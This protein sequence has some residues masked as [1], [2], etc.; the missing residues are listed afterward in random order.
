MEFAG[1]QKNCK[2][3]L[4]QVTKDIKAN[5]DDIDEFETI[6][7]YMQPETNKIFYSINGMSNSTWFYTL[8][9]I[10][11]AVDENEKK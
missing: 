5:H 1:G 7:L 8:D 2:D 9:E 10:V 3:I 4:K 6:D 11:N